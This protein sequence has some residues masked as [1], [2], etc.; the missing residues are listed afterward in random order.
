M[1]SFYYEILSVKASKQRGMSE[2][3]SEITERQPVIIN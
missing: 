1:T 3:P 2:V